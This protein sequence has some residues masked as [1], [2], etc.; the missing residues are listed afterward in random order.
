MKTAQSEVGGDTFVFSV[1][2]FDAIYKI[3]YPSYGNEFRSADKLFEIN[4]N[5]IFSRLRFNPAESMLLH[6][7]KGVLRGMHYQSDCCARQNRLF[8][9]LEGSVFVVVVDL[10][11]D[12]ST[13]GCWHGI[14]ISSEDKMC[15]YIP[16]DF[17]I[18][19][20]AEE[21]SSVMLFYDKEYEPG[22]DRGFRFDDEKIGITWSMPM[23]ALCIAD[24]DL[25]LPLF[26]E[27]DK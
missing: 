18:G 21:D 19:T 5:Y 12:K 8:Y 17:A 11:E 27:R 10:R 23:D 22:Y 25:A 24:K 1:I 26:H 7:R 13:Y 3:Q 20:L 9:V 6:S 16:N 2:A 4:D 15:L 14:R